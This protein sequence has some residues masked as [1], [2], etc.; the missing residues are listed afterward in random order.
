MHCHK[1]RRQ[2]RIISQWTEDGV[3]HIRT[4]DKD[5]LIIT[6]LSALKKETGYTEDQ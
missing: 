1:A 4:K 3:V 5:D 2:N 6:D